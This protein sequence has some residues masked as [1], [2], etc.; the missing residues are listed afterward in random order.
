MNAF[1]HE[2]VAPIPQ[3][4]HQLSGKR[5]IELLNNGSSV[6]AVARCHG[7]LFQ[8]FARNRAQAFEV[9]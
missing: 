6:G 7:A 4:T 2:E 5:L 1:G 9:N 3:H 8:V